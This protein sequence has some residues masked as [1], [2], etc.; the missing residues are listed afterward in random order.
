MKRVNIFSLT[1]QEISTLLISLELQVMKL[2][3]LPRDH[4]LVIGKSN[5]I[6]KLLT[7]GIKAEVHE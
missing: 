5:L 1:D 6:K 4:P 3:A 2:N 7:S